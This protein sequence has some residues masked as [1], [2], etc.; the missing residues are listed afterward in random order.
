MTKD[1]I[2]A[3]DV[4]L[5]GCAGD[6]L[7]AGLLGLVDS[8]NSFLSK[9][10]NAFSKIFD[11][12]INLNIENKHHDDIQGLYLGI[13]KEIQLDYKQILELISQCCDILGMSSNFKVFC[14]DTFQLLLEAERDVHG[15]EEVHLHELGT[16]DTLIDI[17]SS[18]YLIEY[19][20]ISSLQIS[21][22]AT[23]S[24][25]IK[26]SHGILIVPPPVTQ[27]I[28]EL[29]KLET[30]LG[31]ETGEATTPTGAAILAI[32]QKQFDKPNAVVWEQNSYGF[33]TRTWA[34]RGNY[35]RVRLGTSSKTHSQISVLETNVDDVNAEILGHTIGQLMSDGA[36][37]VSYY[38]IM[39]KKNRPA[40]AIKVICRSE[41]ETRIAD[42]I[43][44]LTGTLGIRINSVDRHIGSRKSKII[45]LLIHNRE[46][47]LKIK[48]GKYR[49]KF[50]FDDIVHI[51]K[52]LELSPQEVQKIVERMVDNE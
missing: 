30:C 1:R 27:K 29:S 18:F 16:S 20:N 25:T 51:A 40:Y 50:E 26:T 2:L 38:P 36:L 35:L 5:A 8:H 3:I 7:I 31:P 48:I 28:F 34:D 22:V 21:T 46:F 12:A 37:D 43:M 9:L 42:K 39:M 33:G 52:E 32:L 4:D 47:K 14:I 11:V 13:D 23:G 10:S 19:L 6:M 15:V 45:T 17:V 49:S 24:G 44:R 41:D